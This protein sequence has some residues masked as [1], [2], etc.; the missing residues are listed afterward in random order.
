MTWDNIFNG[1]TSGGIPQM[2]GVSGYQTLYLLDANGVIRATSGELRGE[3]LAESVHKL[4]A[5][6]EEAP[7]GN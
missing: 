6:M 3:R 4:I 7:A 2:W 1:A 5:E